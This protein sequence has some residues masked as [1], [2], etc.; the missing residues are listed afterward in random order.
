MHRLS[1]G[2]RRL[3]LFKPTCSQAAEASR[4]ENV[5]QDNPLTDKIHRFSACVFLQCS[6]RF[7]DSP[8]TVTKSKPVL[9]SFASCVLQPASGMSFVDPFLPLPRTRAN[10]RVLVYES[11]AT[12]PW[13]RPF[14][15]GKVQHRAAPSSQLLPEPFQKSDDGSS[16]SFVKRCPSRPSAQQWQGIGVAAPKSGKA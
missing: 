7:R 12:Q 1:Q 9:A 2:S 15:R 6:D 13:G 8:I 16:G 5:D 14:C 10:I 11:A 3:S 4:R